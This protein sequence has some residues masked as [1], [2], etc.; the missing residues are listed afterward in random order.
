ME[1]V[2]DRLTV[3]AVADDVH[4]SVHA[5][6]EEKGRTTTG[7]PEDTRLSSPRVLAA[8]AELIAAVEEEIDT[9]EAA[10]VD[11]IVGVKPRT[12]TVVADLAVPVD[13]ASG[14][15]KGSGL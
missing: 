12:V 1:L 2:W 3:E 5:E 11:G 9:L 8:R 6:H 14:L 7:A 15:K 4:A 10:K 13:E